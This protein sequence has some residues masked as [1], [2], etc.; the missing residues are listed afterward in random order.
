MVASYN[1]P[2]SCYIYIQIFLLNFCSVL[3][4]LFT[5]VHAWHFILCFNFLVGNGIL[6]E[7]DGSVYE[8]AFHNNKRHGEGVQIYRYISITVYL[9]SSMTA[10]KL[11][12]T[13]ILLSILQ[14]S[15]HV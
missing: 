12:I 9:N 4:T 6:T 1:V 13:S 5:V 15:A 8:G 2:P 7:A 10:Q 3:L 11:I 14:I